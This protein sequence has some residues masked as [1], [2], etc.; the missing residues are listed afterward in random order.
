MK[1]LVQETNVEQVA[2]WFIML[3]MLLVRLHSDI[4]SISNGNELFWNE[5]ELSTMIS[6]LI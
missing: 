2:N 4:G 6:H 3:Q 5:L 1:I